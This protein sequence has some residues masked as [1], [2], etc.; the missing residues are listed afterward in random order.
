[1]KLSLHFFK[2]L[3]P[4]EKKITI[5]T[6]LT[7]MRIVLTP[8]IVGA[9]VL[10][11]WGMA[12]FLFTIAAITDLLDGNIARW[13]GEQ[14]LLGACLDPIADKILIL[15]CFAALAFVQ[16]PLF[17]IPSWFLGIV[18][19]KEIII[20]GGAAIIYLCIG[21][22]KVQPVLVGKITTFVQMIFILWLF[23]CYLFAWIPIKTY[24]TM[25]G[26]VLFLVIISLVQYSVMGIRWLY[27][28]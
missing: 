1:M 23:V 16:F 5:S 22:I 13:R 28:D 15:S 4:K 7:L 3:P 19:T 26:L 12:G 25:L 18:F 17:V 24:Y 9:M 2:R 6:L 21:H 8:A 27:N 20:L 10:H 11:Y 14:T